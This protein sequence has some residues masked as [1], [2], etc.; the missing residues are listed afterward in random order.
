MTILSAV[1]RLGS[2]PKGFPPSLARV[3]VGAPQDQLRVR[4]S[5]N[6]TRQEIMPPDGPPG[7]NIGN[8]GLKGNRNIY[9]C[10]E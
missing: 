1:F 3:T 8:H 6:P 4:G 5:Y 7:V 2:V 10:A 9:Y